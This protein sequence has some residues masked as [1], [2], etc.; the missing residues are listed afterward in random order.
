MTSRFPKCGMFI[1]RNCFSFF[2]QIAWRT[3]YVYLGVGKVYAA[4]DVKAEKELLGK[5]W[6]SKTTVVPR[7]AKLQKLFKT[8]CC[9]STFK[10]HPAA[11]FPCL[12]PVA[13]RALHFSS[14]WSCLLRLEV[15]SDLTLVH[16]AILSHSYAAEL[17]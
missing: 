17:H 12:E 1:L 15:W 14:Q 5:V 16:L 3:H 11:C 7:A 4:G 10:W 9:W 6:M 13:C 2:S 8:A